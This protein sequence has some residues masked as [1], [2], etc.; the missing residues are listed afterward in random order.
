MKRLGT[1][2]VVLFLLG[3]SIPSSILATSISIG[4]YDF[5]TRTSN[6]GYVTHDDPYVMLFIMIYGYDVWFAKYKLAYP[7]G[8][9]LSQTM[10]PNPIFPYSTEIT[11][12]SYNE[13]H[14][15]TVEYGDCPSGWFV[16][17]VLYIECNPDMSGII[18]FERFEYEFD[19]RILT[20][21]IYVACG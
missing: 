18:E 12:Y 20:G 15:W 7:E 21:P 8:L 10:F 6:S 2:L 1:F 5:P 11:S 9:V 4:L 17:G 3:T 14:G 16:G 13:A 19:G